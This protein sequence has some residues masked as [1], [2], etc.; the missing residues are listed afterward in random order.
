MSGARTYDVVQVVIG[1][2]PGALA[3]LF[4][5][6]EDIGVNIEDVHLEHA[7]GLPLGMA[8]LSVQPEAVSA[9]TDA[10]RERG[11]NLPS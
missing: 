4:Q 7:P 8:E 11:W 5:V 2:R 10:L 9:L 1:D 6:A 3:R